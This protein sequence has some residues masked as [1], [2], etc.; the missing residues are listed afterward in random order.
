ML[1]LSLLNVI[2]SSAICSDGFNRLVEGDFV[3]LK[4]TSF[5][6]DFV[7]ES[8]PTHIQHGIPTRFEAVLDVV[9][10]KHG[11]PHVNKAL[12]GMCPAE[13]YAFTVPVYGTVLSY[14]MEILKRYA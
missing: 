6:P 14:N 7:R 13:H 10:G 5:L 12:V 1:G 3:Q 4:L 8:L 11:I 2:L 9:V